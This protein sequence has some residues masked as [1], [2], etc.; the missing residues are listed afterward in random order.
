MSIVLPAARLRLLLGGYI[1]AVALVTIAFALLNARVAHPWIIG[2]WLINY[3]GGFVRRGLLGQALLLVH[4]ATRLPLVGLAGSLQV[5]LYAAFYA[6][7]LPLLRGVRWSLPLLALLLSPAT[8]AFTVLDPPTSVRKEVL[9]LLSI[10]F[11]LHAVLSRRA[12]PWQVALAMSIVA[13]LLIFTHEA[14]LVFLPYLLL[15]LLVSASR[16]REVIGLTMLPV[17]LTAL[18]LAAVVTHPGGP[19]A[20]QAVCASVGGHL[21]G[22]PTDVCHGAIAYLALTPAQARAETLRAIDFYHYG[23]RYPLPMLLTLLP[24]VLL[25]RRRLRAGDPATG[26]LLLVTLLSLLLSFPLFVIARD[27]GRWVEIHA[28]CLLLLF[29]LL[30]RPRFLAVPYDGAQAQTAALKLPVRRPS[31]RLQLL[32]LAVYATCWT[33]PA[34]GIFPGRFGYL[35]LVRYLHSYRSRPHLSTIADGMPAPQPEASRRDGP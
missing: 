22:A 6:S 24:I 32:A 14:L 31:R 29:L 9:L 33:L 7:L 11:C 4:G 13:P 1:A 19:S 25:F 34:V 15:P 2:E 16:R 18:A 21:P 30:E 3:S 20:A 28:T 10:S 27:W 26:L 8:L 12:R 5:L 17:A 23:S 35:D